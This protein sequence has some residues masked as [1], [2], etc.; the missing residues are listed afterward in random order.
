MQSAATERTF[1]APEVR[2]RAITQGFI[3]LV[4][5]LPG[6]FLVGYLGHLIDPKGAHTRDAWHRGLFGGFGLLGAAVSVA[7]VWRCGVAR[8]RRNDLLG[9]GSLVMMFP[10]WLAV[11]MW[12]FFTA[13]AFMPGPIFGG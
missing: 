11:M 9:I 5:A 1:A 7:S 8:D 13:I 12:L 3:A 2:K 10:G 6:F 4:A